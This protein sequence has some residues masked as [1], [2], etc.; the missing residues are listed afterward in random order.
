MAY[1][2]IKV[3]V[4]VKFLSPG[5]ILKGDGYD[6]SGNRVIDKNVP[7]PAGLIDELKSRGIQTVTYSRTRMKIKKNV[8]ESV[9]SEEHLAQAIDLVSEMETAIRFKSEIPSKHVGEVIEG[10]IGD[11][12]KSGEAY[13]N[14]VDIADYDEYTYSHSVNVSTLSL[15]LGYEMGLEPDKLKI[16]GTAGLLHDIGKTLV[17]HEIVS[18]PAPLTPE[19]FQIMRRHPVYGYN[20]LKGENIYNDKVL[21]AVLL[22]HENFKGSGYPLGIT[23]EK[24]NA[25]AQI[26][27]VADVFDAVTSK[28][29]YKGPQSYAEAFSYIMEA[30]G[31]KFHPKIAQTFLKS[32]VKKINETPLY[33]ENSYVLLSTGEIAY[34]VGH[35][36]SLYSLRPIVEI[37]YHPDRQ[38]LKFPQQIDLEG[39]YNRHVVKR[40]TDKKYIAKFNS[41]LKQEFGAMDETVG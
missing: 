37:F 13:L 19:E 32:L 20:I 25:F 41:I 14:L 33:P 39:D 7:I 27:A 3:E 12:E 17:P 16:V 31:E 15:T 6:E 8:S 2:D 1:D 9:I 29:S 18:K 26:V 34:V 11:I 38:F 28:R 40:V 23:G 36:Q 22:H 30:S 4:L 35:R 5:M 21:N 24:T 10:F